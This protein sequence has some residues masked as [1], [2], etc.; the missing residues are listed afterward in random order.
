M[1][2][3]SLSN[4][5]VFKFKREN[6]NLILTEASDH[7]H[8][9]TLFR[10]KITISGSTN[11]IDAHGIVQIKNYDASPS[12]KIQSGGDGGDGVIGFYGGG[13]WIMGQEQGVDKFRIANSSAITGTKALTIDGTNSNRVGIKQDSPSYDLDVT[14]DIRC[15]DNLYV[16]NRI[17]FNATDIAVGSNTTLMEATAGSG[18]TERI[19]LA[20]LINDS[21]NK[22]WQGF[23]VNGS[24]APYYTWFHYEGGSNGYYGMKFRQSGD[25]EIAGELS[26][27][28]DARLKNNIRNLESPLAKVCSLRGVKFDWKY[29][30][31]SKNK[32]GFIAQEVE[33]I[34]PELVI[35]SDEKANGKEGSPQV[36]NPKSVAY[37]NTVPYLVEAI[38]ELTAKVEALEKKLENK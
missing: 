37:A 23:D 35:T 20:H 3:Q 33:K 22:W 12:L 29:K 17:Y 4:G 27:N 34:I 26:E 21:N 10:K 14:G 32:I 13:T 15:T 36:D 8:E 31:D 24:S 5:H 11:S 16:G 2:E 18:A 7:S 6:S 28:S 30:S 9:E 38:K 1:A 25:L 19:T